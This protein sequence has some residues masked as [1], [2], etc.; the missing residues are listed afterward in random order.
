MPEQQ[1]AV[2]LTLPYPMSAWQNAEDFD[3]TNWKMMLARP[4][5]WSVV[6]AVMDLFLSPGA[7]HA[8]RVREPLRELSTVH[9]AY[10]VLKKLQY[11]HRAQEGT[12]TLTTLPRDEHQ[13]RYDVIHLF[14]AMLHVHQDGLTQTEP[15]GLPTMVLDTERCCGKVPCGRARRCTT[16]P[17]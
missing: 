17:C 8:K 1:H 9:E 11:K 14:L 16:L 6:P 5:P 4:I 13:H 15:K 7:T 10:V 2:S 12:V 3:Q